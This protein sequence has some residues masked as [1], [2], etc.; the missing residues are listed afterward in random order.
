ML[1]ITQGKGN[2]GAM[3]VGTDISTAFMEK[4]LMFLKR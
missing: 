4:P 3:L 2:P 1:T